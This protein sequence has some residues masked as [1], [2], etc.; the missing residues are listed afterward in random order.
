MRVTG[1]LIKYFVKSQ[2]KIIDV[3]TGSDDTVLTIRLN[4]F[5][6]CSPFLFF[7]LFSLLLFLILFY[8]ISSQ[9]SAVRG[10]ALLH[11][12]GPMAPPAGRW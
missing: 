1:S 12:S 4:Y 2:D 7:L 8:E 9:F 11:C 10:R 5:S 6:S 3:T